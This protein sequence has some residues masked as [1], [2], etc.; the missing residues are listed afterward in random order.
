[1]VRLND[2]G[3]MVVWTH[4]VTSL[5]P[6]PTVTD[7]FGT[8]VLGRVFNADG[9]PH[10]AVFQVNQSNTN[11]DQGNASLAVLKNGNVEVAWTDRPSLVYFDVAALIYF[12]K[13]SL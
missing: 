12:G 5:F 6:I 10:G 8:A 9:T 11:S 4:L 7:I 13:Y 1:M 3:F 2:D